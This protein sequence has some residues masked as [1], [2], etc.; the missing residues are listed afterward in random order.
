MTDGTPVT[1]SR[2]NG[3]QRGQI[4]VSPQVITA[5]SP[6]TGAVLG[7][8]AVATRLQVQD[9]M[10][11]ARLGRMAWDGIGLARRLSF[12]RALR[13][14]LY[15]QQDRIIGTLVAEQGKLQ[16]EA[17]LEY[18]ATMEMVDFYV[19]QAERILAPQEVSVRLL[20]HRRHFVIRR[21]Y[22]VVLV[23]SPWNY[24]LYLSVGPIVAAL[25]AGNSVLFKPSEYATQIGEAIAG[26]VA[27]AEFPDEVFH[28]LHGYGEVGAMMIEAHPDH[29]CFTGSVSTGKQIARAAAEKL[30]PVTLELGGK[31]AAIVLHNADIE[32]AAAGI[33]WSGIFNAGQ[34]CA[35]VERVYAD[36]RIADRLITAMKHVVEQ[37]V[38]PPDGA[39]ASLAALTTPAQRK[40]VESQVQE[41]VAAGAEVVTG[42]RWAADGSPFFMPTILT[43]V[44]PEMR[45]CQE[46]TFGPVI[47]VV[48]VK[49]AAEAVR[50]SNAS[51]F[52]LT[53]SIWT[54]DRDYGLWLAERL[55]TGTVSI[56]EHLLVSGVAEMPWGGVKESGYGRTQ[57]AE[58]LL[59][60]T[61]SQVVTVDRFRLPRA[62]ELFW[63]PYTPFK[64]ALIRRGIHALYG[65]TWRDR[66]RALLP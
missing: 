30:I 49:D 34:T 62:L 27:E 4:R 14:A 16:Q 7:Q 13:D 10:A 52:G 6:V 25:T 42:G 21:P 63:Y 47:L 39:P 5:R 40:V 17:L 1:D 44:T 11:E 50:L 41:A 56:N 8:V 45:I 24:P 31:D 60:M 61:Y 26:V 32:R 54:E 46:E 35:S 12:I 18:L 57:G 20:P 38:Q 65:P 9:A 48:P 59:G 36:R 3:R 33:V 64:R 23:I 15:R 55:Q 29:I 58:G 66:L 2:V 53:A 43:N 51:T 22:G 37:Y 28:I 19:R